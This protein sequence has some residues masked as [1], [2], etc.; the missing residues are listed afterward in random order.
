MKRAQ[1]GKMHIY[2]YIYDINREGEKLTEK[3]R[4]KET[5][6]VANISLLNYQ[7]DCTVLQVIQVD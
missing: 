1:E 5:F 6:G 7:R 4:H 3:E 2:A